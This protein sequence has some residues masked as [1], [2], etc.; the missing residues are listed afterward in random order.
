MSALS[1][2]NIQQRLSRAVC[3]FPTEWSREGLEERYSWLKSPHEALSTPLSEDD[4]A[5]LMNHARDLAFWESIQ[6]PDLPSANECWHFPPTAFIQQF[7]R[8]WWFSKS[9]FKQLLPTEVLRERTQT[10]IYYEDVAMSRP[11][12]NMIDNHLVPLNK[13]IRKYRISSHQRLAAF[14]GNSL[15]ETTWLASLHE[16]NAAAW[17]YPWDGRGFLQLTHPANYFS[18]WD[19]TARA[20]QIPASVRQS[21]LNHHS[22]ANAHRP[23]AQQ[24]NADGVNGASQNVIQWRDDVGDDHDIS[25]D[26]ISPS[27]SAGFYWLMMRMP[28][29]AD[30]PIR[31]VRR[32]VSAT[33]PPNPH[34]PTNQPSVIKIYY[35][36]DNFRDASAIVNLPAA[37][38]HPEYPFNG[39]IARCRAFGQVLAV[40]SEVRFPGQQGQTHEFPEG[41]NP[42]RD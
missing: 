1:V 32:T 26:L 9:E 14:F 39:Y 29:Y 7:R 24:Y 28:E 33:R 11:R 17:Y 22:Q 5:T 15:Q 19:F 40:V 25:R 42:R 30:R 12:Q 18:Y 31:L 6:D 13:A 34:H 23:T 36:S 8:C 27:D 35:H 41:C 21:V 37:V 4:F 2:S 16:N 20:R 10:V 38:G 3:Q